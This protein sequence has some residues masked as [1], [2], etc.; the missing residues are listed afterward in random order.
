MK[1]RILTG[2]VY[3]IVLFG[4]LAL[5][6]LTPGGWGSLGFDALFCAISVIS[7]LELLNALKG[8]SYPQK[9][10]TVAFCAMVVPLYVIVQMTMGNGFLAVGCSGLLYASVLAALNVFH[11]GESTVH[12][13]MVCLMTMLYCGILSVMLSAVNHLAG[14]SLA[15]VM[16]LFGTAMATDT[17]AYVI[18]SIF[19][20]WIPFKLAP[21]LS[22][23]K[24]VIGG[25][26]GLLG[27]MFGAVVAYFVYYG[28]TF[29]PGFAAPRLIYYGNMPAVLSFMFIGLVASIFAQ[30][31]DLF[32]SAIKRECNIKDT[33]KLLP[34]HGGVLDRFDSML[35]SCVIV[36]FSFGIII[37]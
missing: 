37:L 36:L 26:G 11:H 33:G 13:T 16:V 27:G 10:V 7:A 24:T 25:I 22:P 15:A 1:K 31:G 35:F 2:V 8:V 28:L 29:V 30:I 19:K 32:E 3:V 34:G 9:V 5:K 6:W 20:R 23:N 14:N 17:F 4:L 12:G 18:G 21:K